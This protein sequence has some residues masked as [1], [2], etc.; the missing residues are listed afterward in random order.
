VPRTSTYGLSNVTLP[1]A[2]TLADQGF[3]DAVRHD[4]SLAQGVNIYAGR[5]TYGA[6]AEAFGLP[7][8]PL[9]EL[10]VGNTVPV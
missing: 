1:Y 3:L 5:I 4:P 9:A 6:V 10:L 2:L 7:Y 8:T